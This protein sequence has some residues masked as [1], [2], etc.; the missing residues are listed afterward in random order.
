MAEGQPHN[1]WV[2]V[3]REREPAQV[4]Y[5]GRLALGLDVNG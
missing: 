4:L 2:A 3:I 5:T 1:R